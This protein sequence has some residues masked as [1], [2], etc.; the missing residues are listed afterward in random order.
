MAFYTIM[1]FGIQ[2]LFQNQY[3]GWAYVLCV[4]QFIGFV[5]ASVAIHNTEVFK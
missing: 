2:W 3:N 4:A 5:M 1:P